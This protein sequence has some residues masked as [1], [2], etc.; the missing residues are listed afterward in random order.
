MAVVLPRPLRGIVPPLVTPLEEP[1]RLDVEGL[2]RVLERM[3]AAGVHAVFPL[4]STGEAP[5]LSTN[6]RREVLRLVCRI[7]NGRVPVLAGITDCSVDE[8]ADLSEHA[9]V[10][11]CSAVVFAAPYY[12]PMN[13][14]D[15]LKWSL[16]LA[17]RLPLPFFLYNIPS[18]TKTAFSL[19]TVAELSRHPLCHGVKDTSGDWDFFTALIEKF[20]PRPEFA[21]LLG[22]EE[23]LYPALEAGADGAVSGGANLHPELYV[24]IWDAFQAGRREEA[25]ELHGLVWLLYERIYG[26]AGYPRSLKCAMELAGI[27]SGRM[28]ESFVE[29][30]EE[31]RERIRG[32]LRTLGLI[33]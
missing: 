16:A 5:A 25:A 21:V 26:A 2:E 19:E 13:Q 14:A 31:A 12:F 15:L 11:G 8:A 17:G 28:T 4:G 18:H 29:P 7:V 24:R 33:G 3:L 22:P 6:L 1:G 32:A 30:D 9:A 10:Y 27:C 20:R 23:M